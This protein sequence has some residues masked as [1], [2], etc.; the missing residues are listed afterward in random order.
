MQEIPDP[1]Q[2]PSPF[3]FLN[4]VWPTILWL[5]GLI[6]AGISSLFAAWQTLKLKRI[7]A[8]HNLASEKSTRKMTLDEKRISLELEQMKLE[9]A[10]QAKFQEDLMTTA[11]EMMTECN[12]LRIHNQ[13]LMGE[14]VKRDSTIYERDQEIKKLQFQVEALNVRVRELERKVCE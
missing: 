13:T 14:V 5:L 9:F 6:V 3:A 7:E 10:R 11:K 8:E 1:S 2:I 4:G 12:T